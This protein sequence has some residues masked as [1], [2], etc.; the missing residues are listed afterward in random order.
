MKTR[1]FKN[2]N[3]SLPKVWRALEGYFIKRET[4]LVVEF[5]SGSPASC[6]SWILSTRG[7]QAVFQI[8]IIA[9]SCLSQKA[10][11]SYSLTAQLYSPFAEFSIEWDSSLTSLIL[12]LA[13][14]K[15]YSQRSPEHWGLSYKEPQENF[16]VPEHNFVPW[17][18]VMSLILS[19]L[20]LSTDLS[21]IL[22]LYIINSF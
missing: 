20:M 8:F 5:S 16:P 21:H 11:L 12:S 14:G 19:V 18:Q 17:G 7:V 3:F 22:T 4:Q 9:E 15:S 10:A 1:F 2:I 6:F 13:R